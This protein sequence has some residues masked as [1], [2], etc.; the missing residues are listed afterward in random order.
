MARVENKTKY[1]LDTALGDDDFLLGTDEGAL[2]A[3]KSYSLLS[4]SAFVQNDLTNLPSLSYQGFD[5][6][7]TRAGGNLV[8]IMG[9]YDDTAKGTKITLNDVNE[10][11][12][13]KADAYV[14]T[15]HDLQIGNTAH[16]FF[17]T[18]D[19]S[20][21]SASRVIL[22]PNIGG[23]LVATVN[24]T[25]PDAA[26]N[27]LL[28]VASLTVGGIVELATIAETDTGTDATRAMTPA[29]LKGSALQTKVDGVEALADVTDATNVNA[30]GATMTAD[31]TLAGYGYFLDEDTMSSD[32]AT[33]VASQQS[34]KK[35]V[36]DSTDT[37][38]QNRIVVTTANV[39][40][41]LG[42]TIDSTKEYF[43]DGVV[44][45]TGVP[46]TVPSGG[47][48]ITG[49]NFNISKLTCLDI[50]YTMFTSAVGGSGD[51]LFQDIAIEVTG[52]SSK[53][54]D[55]VGDTGDEAFEINRVNFNGCTSLGEISTYRQGLEVGTG[56][57]DG[58]PELTLTGTW[59]GGYFIDTSIVRSLVDGSYTLYKAG[60]AFS[61]AS[62]FRSNQNADLN[63]TVSFFDFAASNFT[64]PST[65]QLQG[66]IITRNG[67]SSASDAT[68][69]PNML[70]S[71]LVSSWFSNK[72]L[73]NTFVGGTL[74][75]TA[76]T[77]TTISVINTFVD[78]AGTYTATGLVHF[79]ESANGRLRH[80]GNDPQEYDII[81]D[82]VVEGT[83]S[84][85]LAIKIV[86][87][88]NS[89]SSFSDVVTQTR[90]VNSLVGGRNVAFFNI[91]T[92]VTLDQNDYVKI[93]VA[94]DTSTNNCTAEADSYFI[95]KEK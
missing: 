85:E 55:L 59:S 9:D 16:A 79:D 32:D 91:F 31:T 92:S 61:M 13:L 89:A 67:V 11:V 4:I 95:V 73:P 28:P 22:L 36:E 57:F 87:W 93:Q 26:G 24:S 74:N 23:V 29:G 77:L 35:F 6:T 33:K 8:A 78:L 27:V 53:V 58:T 84:E 51:I 44:N 1:P 41:T 12:I 19:A 40:T 66:C 56:R 7:G 15:N 52:A 69:I 63:A 49:Y 2:K 90:E 71:D 39:A 83:T 72:G 80:L 46:I 5:D 94:N 38:V 34:I 65:V 70:N 62:R 88:D 43:L 81:S 17:G 50:S 42:G 25:A 86:K 47:I 3:T 76:E 20:G 75:I 54:F 64:N 48:Y 10:T 21:L 18:L 45:C 60:T 30:A 68:L 82:L 14:Q 37:L